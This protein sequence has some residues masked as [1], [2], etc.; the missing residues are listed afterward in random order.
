MDETSRARATFTDATALA[1]DP[2][3]LRERLEEDGYAF[4]RGLLPVDPLRALGERL[5]REVADAGWLVQGA[6]LERA[7][8]EPTASCVDP[9]P[10]YE[11]VRVRL[12]AIEAVHRLLHHPRIVELFRG[13]FGEA[14]LP[15]PKPN[16][17]AYFPGR[18]TWAHHDYF[19]Q[20]G[21]RRE[22]TMWIPMSDCPHEMGGLEVAHGSHLLDLPGGVLDDAGKAAVAESWRGGDYQLGDVVVFNAKTV[23]RAPHNLTDRL[24][25]SID[26]RYQPRAEPISEAALIHEDWPS[27]YASWTSDACKFYW[28]RWPIRELRV[29]TSGVTEAE[30]AELAA[31]PVEARRAHIYARWQRGFAAAD[32]SS[33]DGRA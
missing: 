10:R 2:A 8:A 4:L 16:V 17:R 31:L 29:D 15:H 11:P 1:R 14:V 33:D 30:L 26:L 22:Y 24:R 28:R 3:A 25:L 27:V 18:S 12:F 20:Q 6:P 23:H 7:L 32:A 19:A 13:V 9:D 5:L 21:S